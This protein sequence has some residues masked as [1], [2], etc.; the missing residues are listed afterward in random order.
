M[1][2]VDTAILQITQSIERLLPWWGVSDKADIQL[3]SISE[4]AVFLIQSSN[5]G[6]PFVVRVHR[7]GYNCEAE[8]R[9]ELAWIHALRK[10]TLIRIVA[11]IPGQDGAVLRRLS[12]GNWA[13]AFEFV[14]GR[15]PS[16]QDETQKFF[17]ELGAMTAQLHQHAREWQQPS[18]F[19]RKRWDIQN[20]LGR[21]G[22]WGDWRAAPGLD[23]DGVAFLE[24]VVDSVI[25]RLTKYGFG[26]DRF[27]L[28]HGDL[29]MA[30]VIITDDGL[31]LLDFDDCG[32]SWFLCDYGCAMTDFETGSKIDLLTQA[33]ILGYR[34]E[35]DLSQEDEEVLPTFALLRRLITMAWAGSHGQSPVA[36][37]EYGASYTAQTV[38]MAELYIPGT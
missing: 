4:N 22:I 27:G 19:T 32:M 13:V 2:S 3:L 6:R 18:G 11:P 37:N 31:Y 33:W 1:S 9:S 26:P 38:A 25:R 14:K 21:N 36:I 7:S 28:I 20:S 10:E 35:S 12:T 29:K 24:P 23:R 30:N 15:A 17:E 34:S 8:I 5:L 16:P